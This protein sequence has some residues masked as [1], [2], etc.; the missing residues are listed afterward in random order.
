MYKTPVTDMSCCYAAPR[1]IGGFPTTIDRYPSLVQVEF[2][3][4]FAQTWS[5]SCAANILN[6]KYVLS[7]AHCFFGLF[8]SPALRRIRAGTTYRNS[9]GS[10]VEV[11]REFNHPTFG[12]NGADGDITVVRLAGYGLEFNPVIKPVYVVHPQSVIPDNQ[13]VIHA[14]WGTTELGTASDVL[15]DVTVFTVNREICRERY[16]KL[17]EPLPI[18]ENMI[19]AGL[20][21]V[22]G[23]DACQGDSGGPLYFG[24]TLI[25]VVS[26]GEGCANA[27][28]PGVS[29]SVGPY[30][31]WIQTV[32]F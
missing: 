21:D 3:S 26:F 2:R 28:F 27:T 4:L 11:E 10:I 5:Q 18:T 6:E 29:T 15:R 23:R 16:A 30:V 32:A 14:G 31:Q 20:L 19:C 13:P 8:Y 7:A 1:I 25:G 9:G 12:Q 24:N 17:E 22:G